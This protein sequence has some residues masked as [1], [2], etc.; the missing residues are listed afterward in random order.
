MKCY[1]EQ[2]QDDATNDAAS[3]LTELNDIEQNMPVDT[4]SEFWHPGKLV[5]VNNWDK[6]DCKLRVYVCV[7]TV[8]DLMAAPVIK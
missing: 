4:A 6:N 3:L 5:S 7:C 1:Y 8:R 2:E